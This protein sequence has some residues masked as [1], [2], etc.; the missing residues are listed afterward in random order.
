VVA[1]RQPCLSIRLTVSSIV[2]RPGMVVA[3][4]RTT[5]PLVGTALAIGTDEVVSCYLDESLGAHSW[6]FPSSGMFH[7]SDG[8]APMMGQ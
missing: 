6:S 2:G 1:Q 4:A 7:R 5:I 3:R 8:S